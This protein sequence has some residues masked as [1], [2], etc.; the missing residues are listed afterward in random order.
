MPKRVDANQPQ[1]VADLR[2]RG[3]L[4]HVTSELGRG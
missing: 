1:L 4:V 2:G 3:L